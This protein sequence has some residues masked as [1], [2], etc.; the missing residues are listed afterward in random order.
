MCL[1][2]CLLFVA[3][4]VSCDDEDEG[5]SCHSDFRKAHKESHRKKT[6]RSHKSRPS[7]RSPAKLRKRHNIHTV[8]D[9]K[10][11]LLSGVES[12]STLPTKKRRRRR[13]IIIIII[14]FW[15]NVQYHRTRFSTN[16]DPPLVLMCSIKVDGRGGDI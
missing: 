7:E 15:E 1:A 9:E 14:V 10:D 8:C 13:F 16:C 6:R 3:L 4:Y 11:V 2:P 12:F 5:M